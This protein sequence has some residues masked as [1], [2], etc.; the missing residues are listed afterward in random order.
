VYPGF[1]SRN[2]EPDIQID[3]IPVVE[4]P[5]SKNILRILKIDTNFRWFMITRIIFQFGMMSFA[6]YTVYAVQH[7][8]INETSAGFLASA[9]MISQ[10]AANPLLGWIADRWSRKGV[11][12]IGA[13]TTL[14][15][16]LLAW[17]A[18]DLAWFFLVMV[19]TGFSNTAF[20]TIGLAVSL[21]FG[22]EQEQATYVGMSNTLIAPST[23][24]APLLGGWLADTGGYPAC[25]IAGTIFSLVTYLMLHFFVKDPERA[26]KA[27]HSL[28]VIEEKI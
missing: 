25:F 21:E 11:L 22:P 28:S 5:L 9:L 17:L 12:E 10:T 18:P 3:H 8:H 1:L 16:S 23:I 14:L 13:L 6:F 7:L 26:A 27:Q 19:L 2:K 15:S 24:L 4:E 20:W